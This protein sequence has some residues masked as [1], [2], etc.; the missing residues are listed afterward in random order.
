VKQS[1]FQH[2]VRPAILLYAG[3]LLLVLAGASQ[4][5]PFVAKRPQAREYL[6]VLQAPDHN[7]GSQLLG[8]GIAPAREAAHAWLA[9]FSFDREAEV[10]Q[11][12]G[13]KDIKPGVAVLIQLE[14]GSTTEDLK[15][16]LEALHG[17]ITGTYSNLPTIAAVLPLESMAEVRKLPGVKKVSKQKAYSL[18][19]IR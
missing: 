6:I 11:M 18:T 16:R 19:N 1:H 14:S 3:I 2:L 15:T 13:V 8:K 10:R 5:D 17:V 7:F 12:R 9:K 4:N